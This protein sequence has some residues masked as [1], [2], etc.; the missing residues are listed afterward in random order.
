M[1]L[2]GSALGDSI[3]KKLINIS[4]KLK[5]PSISVIEHWSWYKKRFIL[6]NNL[7]LPDYIFVNDKI[8]YEEAI[9]DGLPKKKLLIKGNPVLEKIQIHKGNTNFI[10]SAGCVE[11]NSIL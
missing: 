1:F 5:K 4:K 9:M 6:N 2:T 8:A 11:E 3:D 7:I 10:P